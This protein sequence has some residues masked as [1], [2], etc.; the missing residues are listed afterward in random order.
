VFILRLAVTSALIYVG[1]ALAVEVALFSVV[2]MTGSSLIMASKFGWFIFF[3]VFW[4]ISFWIAF[5][6]SPFSH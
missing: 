4:L 5:R 3:G 1:F 2:K 6:I